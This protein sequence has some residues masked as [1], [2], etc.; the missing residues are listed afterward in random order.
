MDFLTDLT[1]WL[2]N[3]LVVLALGLGLTLTALTRGVQ[4]RLLPEMIRQ[5]F[6]HKTNGNDAKEGISSSQALMLTLSSRIGVGN[7]AGVA[8]A[9]AAGGPGALFWMGVMGFLGCSLAFVESTVAQIYKRRVDGQLWGGIPY[10]IERGLGRKWLA[11]VAAA[12]AFSLYAVL[13]PGVQSNSISAAL[14]N[15]MGID[16]WITGVVV[17][18]ALGYVIFGG[19][20]R[21]VAVADWLV[22]I[23]AV[24]YI[25]A[26]VVVLALNTSAVPDAVRLILASAFGLD[27]VFGGIVGA[28]IAWGVRRAVFS[29]VAGAGEATY[30]AAAADV[31][32][33]VKQGL[34][35][36][37]S[38]YID[39]LFVCMATG[40]MIVV[41]GSYNVRSADDSP[42]VTNV[43][44]VEAGA[45][46]TQEAVSS[47]FAQAGPVFVALA[48]L[49]FAYTAL[50]AFYFIAETN[51]TY[52]CRED[53]LPTARTV[54]RLVMMAVVL[55]GS[56]QSADLIWAIGDVGYA[57]LAW[58][59]MLCLVFLAKPA[60]AALRDYD[61]QRRRGVDPVFDPAAVGISGADYWER[62]GDATDTRRT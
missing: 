48:I 15:G 21:I 36:S 51:L 59:N 41:T 22:P 2:W 13:A 9:I 37:F 34:I 24:G 4:I 35:Q 43:P 44:G 23:M 12:T 38:I 54:A 1:D 28:A 14:H 60:L 16:P 39:T 17:T 56:V 30:G 31:S 50:I 27:S 7:I 29:N 49:L 61:T 6:G 42:I 25:L 45:A 8:T 58:V 32:H 55:F 19:R 5:I 20:R 10:Y 40:L 11:I 47:V 18:G 62:S 52:L 33:P 46:Y 3:P 57:S 53:W 26:A